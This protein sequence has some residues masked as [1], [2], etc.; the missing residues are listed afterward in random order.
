VST[1]HLT[2][3]TTSVGGEQCAHVTPASEPATLVVVAFEGSPARWLGRWETAVGERPDRVTF[4]LAED[5]LSWSGGDAGR[6]IRRAAPPATDVDVRGVSSPGNLT[7]LG[8]TLTEVLDDH[9][10][11]AE[12]VVC[13]Q[14]VTVLLQ[15]SPVAEV[16]QFLHTLVAQIAR[17]EG[18]AHVHL[19]DPAH[20]EEIVKTL[21][22]LFDRIRDDGG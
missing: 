16:Y 17:N 9:A 1:L 11:G 10:S 22:P 7:G 3:A 8:V 12:P 20:A 4:V 6:R 5:V 18:T 19:H 13:V 14:S 15:Y 2:D 21:A